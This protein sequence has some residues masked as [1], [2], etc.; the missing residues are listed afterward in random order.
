MNLV[1]YDHDVNLVLDNKIKINMRHEVP[2]IFYEVFDSIWI[3][4][5]NRRHLNKIGVILDKCCNIS[6]IIIKCEYVDWLN[7][8]PRVNDLTL[9]STKNSSTAVK[10]A[11]RILK[12]MPQLTTLKLINIRINYDLLAETNIYDISTNMFCVDDLNIF[13]YNKVARL[14]VR[15]AIM[16]D[17]NLLKDK[18]GCTTVVKIFFKNC[19]EYL[20]ADLYKKFS[21]NV[22]TIEIK[23]N[24]SFP[25]RC[26]PV[27]RNNIKTW[28]A[29]LRSLIISTYKVRQKVGLYNY[30]LIINNIMPQWI[31]FVVINNVMDM[32]MLI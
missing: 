14:T 8:L 26:E 17:I 9:Y 12:F 11:E 6:R 32:V 24:G 30:A 2:Q 31:K 13:E 20:F 18:L 27:C 5:D 29:D 1:L 25:P 19:E 22:Y 3:F 21:A 16:G 10:N 28:I 23:C 15:G 7:N 4:V